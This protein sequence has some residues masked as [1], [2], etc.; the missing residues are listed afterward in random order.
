MFCGIK[1]YCNE[2]CH[3]TTL[4]S[5][6]CHST[7]R[8]VVQL[9]PKEPAIFYGYGLSIP[10]KSVKKSVPGRVSSSS[11]HFQMAPANAVPSPPLFWY[12][13]V[14]TWPSKAFHCP[15]IWRRFAWKVWL[16]VLGT[17]FCGDIQDMLSFILV[18]N[19]HTLYIDGQF[20]VDCVSTL[21]YW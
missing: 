12:G 13:V 10:C 8:T 2:T 16:F 19:Y 17:G 21:H 7:D 9:K 1:R 3:L 18:S 5:G 11:T 14:H 15:T 20:A 6:P 4:L